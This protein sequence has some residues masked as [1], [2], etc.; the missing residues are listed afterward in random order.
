MTTA[1]KWPLLYCAVLC[2]CR[3]LCYRC[4]KNM[5][6]PPLWRIGDRQ[7]AL[8]IADKSS[9]L[10][11]S[12]PCWCQRRPIPSQWTSVIP[13]PSSPSTPTCHIW[14]QW[15][16]GHHTRPTRT[17]VLLVVA[18]Q[19]AWCHHPHAEHGYGFAPRW[20]CRSHHDMKVLCCS[21]V[22]H[23]PVVVCTK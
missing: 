9:P 16:L 21:S 17:H 6:I 19:W 3:A 20:H 8:V 23:S 12:C 13:W 4:T 1:L 7:K 22:Q 18:P 2:S 10:S 5:T 14:T 11:H 15:M